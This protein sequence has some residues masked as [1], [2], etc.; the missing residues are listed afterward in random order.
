M[1]LFELCSSFGYK[2]CTGLLPL[3]LC[4]SI[5]CLYDS[6]CFLLLNLTSRCHPAAWNRGT[7]PSPEVS[8]IE[9]YKKKR[10]KKEKK[11]L[12]DWFYSYKKCLKSSYAMQEHERE[13]AY[14]FV[15][16]CFKALL[17]ICL[18]LL[19]LKMNIDI[20]CTILC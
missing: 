3:P 2:T 20:V 5:Y 11:I 4:F 7:W 14:L 10:V 13:I 19:I 9:F 8:G 12:V 17:I 6:Y 1:I 15:G 18:K 16:T